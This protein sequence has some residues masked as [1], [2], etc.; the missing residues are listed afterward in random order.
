LA[1]LQQYVR[2][3]HGKV[4][5][6]ASLDHTQQQQQRMYIK[7]YKLGSN[8]SRTYREVLHLASLACLVEA[9]DLVQ[10]WRD[11]LGVAA[12]AAAARLK[13]KIRSQDEVLRYTV[14]S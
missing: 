8:G 2:R 11:I 4:L 9:A 10:G 1:V 3:P 5:Y 12:A 7:A 14:R 6:L 13:T